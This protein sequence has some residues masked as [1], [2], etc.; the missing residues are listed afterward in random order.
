MIL[1]WQS[2]ANIVVADPG[3]Y[4][5][6]IPNQALDVA[7]SRIKEVPDV[8][9]TFIDLA[10]EILDHSASLPQDLSE[11]ERMDSA[12]KQFHTIVNTID[13]VQLPAIEAYDI[14]F[15]VWKYTFILC[16][17]LKWTFCLIGSKEQCMCC[18]SPTSKLVYLFSIIYYGIYK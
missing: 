1:K 3:K 4:L 5:F 14:L 13:N 7:L 8:D 15:Q 17:G 10:H 2:Y 9:D 6:P 12:A 18:K 16:D 11:W